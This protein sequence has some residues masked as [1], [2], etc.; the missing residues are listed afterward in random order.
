MK[1]Y[2][3]SEERQQA[4]YMFISHGIF[5]GILA[6]SGK[7]MSKEER[8]NIKYIVTYIGKYFDALRERV[9]QKE[10][11]RICKEGEGNTVVIK[12]KRY[13]G[14]YTIDK[15]ALEEIARMA[16]EANCFGC[17]REDFHECELHN[18]MKKAGMG[19]VGDSNGGRCDFYYEKE[20]K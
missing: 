11:M 17:N 13:D 12:P 15:N 18:Y 9:G 3:N 4:M 10:I 7:N 14:M 16:V 5:S 8:T 19:S 1:G 20:G 6:E 2:L